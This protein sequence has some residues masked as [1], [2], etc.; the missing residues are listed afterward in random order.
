MRSRTLLPW[1]RACLTLCLSLI[2]SL[3]FGL[4][5]PASHA[6]EMTLS[7]LTLK[8]YA[9]NEFIWAWGAPG[10][11][12]PIAEDLSVK[13]PAH[14]I[15]DPRI[16]RCPG[17]GLTGEISIKGLGENYS[18]TL[19]RIGFLNAEPR[20]FTL[21]SVQPQALLT[22]SG[23]DERGAAEIA[24]TYT[25]LGIQHILSGI[26]HLLFVITLLFL[27]GFNKRLF[28]TVTAFTVAHSI[29]LALSALGW[30][31]LRPA[32]V[33]ACIALSIVLVAAEALSKR[34]TWTKQLPALV[35]LLFGLVHG[36][37]FAGALKEIGLPENHFA[38]SLFGFNLGVE[39]GQLA[40][41]AL[42][43]VVYR[44]SRNL[45][46]VATLRRSALYLIGSLATF[47][48]LTRIVQIF[49]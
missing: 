14:C 6:H 30:L 35:A 43:W 49:S 17:K 40:V 47:W 8:E 4:M 36:L 21:T 41:L 10:K 7:E 33:E 38:L 3:V 42:A 12:R 23:K 16:L 37:G 28:W 48:T 25:V 31:A 5:A 20:V 18:A 1:L 39:I 2:L 24:S 34:Q 44:F 13:F 29:T 19:L 45:Q 11:N 22:S 27:V 15:V 32:P 9:P 46:I 26:D